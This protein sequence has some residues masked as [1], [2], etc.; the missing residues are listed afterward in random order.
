METPQLRPG[1]GDRREG[2]EADA[3]RNRNT[4]HVNRKHL[5][6]WLATFFLKV[7]GL[8]SARKKDRKNISRIPLPGGS[9]TPDRVSRLQVGAVKIEKRRE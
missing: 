8:L 2:G 5:N 7:P 4:K 6:L 3:Q 1:G 9:R